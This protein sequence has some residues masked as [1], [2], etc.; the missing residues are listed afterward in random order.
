[1]SQHILDEY[2]RKILDQGMRRVGVRTM[3]LTWIPVFCVILALSLREAQT[4]GSTVTMTDRAS[5]AVLTAIMSAELAVVAGAVVA[6]LWRV[7]VYLRLKCARTDG[8]RERILMA[9]EGHDEEEFDE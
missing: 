5:F 9:I 1:M 3:L 8:D 2:R 4:L 7:C 6:Y